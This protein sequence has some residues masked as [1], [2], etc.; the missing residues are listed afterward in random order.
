MVSLDSAVHLVT[1]LLLPLAAGLLVSRLRCDSL[2]KD[3]W[4]ARFSIMLAVVGCAGMAFSPTPVLMA[5]ST[6]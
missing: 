1:L 2:T 6:I 5:L 4:L 3:W